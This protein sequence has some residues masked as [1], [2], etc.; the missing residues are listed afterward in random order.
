MTERV[1]V[2][3][4]S[5]GQDSTAA[6]A[7]AATETDLDMLVYLD[8]G[9]GAQANREYV[10]TIADHL[11]LQLW[12][13]RTHERYSDMVHEHGFPGSGVHHICYTK[14]K[15]RQI[16]KLATVTTGELHLWTGVRRRESDR[17]M[18]TVEPEQDG[19]RWTWHAPLSE[20]SKEAVRQYIA[21]ND[22]PE[23]ELWD[24]LG[25]SADCWCGAYGSPE[26]LL[27]AEA[28][29]LDDVTDQIREL[30]SAVDRDDAK[31]KWAWAGMSAVQQ[32]AERAEGNNMQLC[33]KCWS[34][35]PDQ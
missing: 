28:A 7:K 11:G 12:T 29:G 31:G 10:E 20:W 2:A 25:R 18:T 15:E 14:L 21:D 33:S 32:R 26:E 24:T 5:G 27:D 6:A 13:L 4:V 34:A 17:R 3:L 19:G 1:D 22:L 8:T 16:S 35:P 23:S 30:E 9:T